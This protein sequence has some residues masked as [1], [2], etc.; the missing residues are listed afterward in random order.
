MTNYPL[1]WPSGW[2]RT[3]IRKQ[4]RFGKRSAQLST[5]YRH[6]VVL[7]VEDATT[8]V[9]RELF[10]FGVEDG[11]AIIS[12]NLPVRLD[13]LPRSN[14]KEPGD[15]GVAVYWKRH[16]DTSHKVMAIDLYDRVA[17]NLAAIA[18]TLEA[19]RSIE[20]HGGAVIL[21]RAFL[22]FQALPAPNTWRSVFGYH[23]EDQ[24]SIGRLRSDYRGLCKNHHPDCGGSES[25]MQEVN[26]AMAEAEKELA[27]E[28]R[29]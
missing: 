19:M 17:D 16:G 20:R 28:V 18:A 3:S 25:K 8:R 1:S 7:S 2:R 26:W 13:G 23:E 5:S 4:A 24:V 9:L 14:Q 22:G 10:A 11:D 6:H 27:D 15:P 29:T 21:D 12:T